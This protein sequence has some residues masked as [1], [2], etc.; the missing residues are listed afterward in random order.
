MGVSTR[1]FASL[2]AVAAVLTTSVVRLAGQTPAPPTGAPAAGAPS[3][4]LSPAQ[5][6][7]IRHS[8]SQGQ[9][10]LNL[11]DRQLRFYLEIVAKA[12]TFADYVKGYDFLNG[13]TKRGDPMSHKEFLN[14]VT[15]KEMYSSAGI[16]PVEQLQFAV[17]NALGQALIRKALDDIK[18]AKDER[19]VEEIRQRID[20]ELAALNGK[21]PQ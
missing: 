9:D 14:L 8:L 2:V 13:P 1:Q 6:D 17:T 19:E 11:D 21:P 18:N 3:T 5:L 16:T 10:L 15:P 12:P 4:N 20:Q 7:R